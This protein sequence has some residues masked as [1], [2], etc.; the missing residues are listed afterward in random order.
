MPFL[1]RLHEDHTTGLVAQCDVCGKLIRD[2]N[3]A[4]I[5]WDGFCDAKGKDLGKCKE[6]P[7]VFYR[8]RIACKGKCTFSLDH[9]FGHQFT[10][11]LEAG[12]GYLMNNCRVDYKRMRRCM[13]VLIM[14]DE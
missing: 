9:E 1:L 4:N 12:I 10:Q 8:Y 7:P 5:C 14:L 13:A 6:V 11:G 2:A 3:L